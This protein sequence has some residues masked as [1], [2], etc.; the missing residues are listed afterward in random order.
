MNTDYEKFTPA[1]VERYFQRC[2]FYG[3]WPG[4]FDQDAA[5]KD[6][7]WASPK[8]WYE[9]DRALFKKYIPLLQRVTVAG[10]QPITA[11]S[12]DNPAVWLE[13]Y[14]SPTADRFYLTLFNDTEQ[15]QEGVVTLSRVVSSLPRSMRITELV[16]GETP[17]RIGPGWRV[18]LLPKAAAVLEFTTQN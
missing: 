5:S 10:W 7:Y 16:S 9:R 2:L 15:P 18:R 6:P 13:R 11:A 17:V 3:V 8:R 4:F 12:C 1:L 14:G